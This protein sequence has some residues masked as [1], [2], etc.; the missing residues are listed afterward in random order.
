[1]SFPIQFSS[2][3]RFSFMQQSSGS[4]DGAMVKR[5]VGVSLELLWGAIPLS[6]TFSPTY[7]DTDKKALSI[8]GAIRLMKCSVVID[9][10]WFSKT[11]SHLKKYHMK[12]II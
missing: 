4:S 7:A 5:F 2:H 3:H 11:L 9:G 8:T 10:S 6:L 12:V 1:L